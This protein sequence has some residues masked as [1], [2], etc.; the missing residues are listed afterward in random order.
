MRLGGAAA[1]DPR[2]RGAP[3]PT[4]ANGRV[5][6]HGHLWSLPDG[7]GLHAPYGALAR[8]DGTGRLCC[9]LCGRFF[10][11]LGGHVRSHGYT[12]AAYR[13][14]MGLGTTTV[15]VAPDV[16]ARISARQTARWDADVG[17]RE[18]FAAG[19]EMARSGELGRRSAAARAVTERRERSVAQ[20]AALD[21]G[22]ASMAAE[23][24]NDLARR[25]AQLGSPSLTEHLRRRYADGA[26]VAAL[27]A[28]TG[29]G[30]ARLRAETDRAG[31]VRRAPGSTTP[32]GRRARA[33]RADAVAAARIGT[34]D[35]VGWLVERRAAGRPL[36]ELAAAVGHSTHWVRWRLPSVPEHE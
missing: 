36:S 14:T 5:S 6:G 12:A 1:E 34:E 23:R 17:V 9:H 33:V 13:E 31:V 22:R 15:L 25:L 27:A 7:T 26:S 16:G 2:R 19:Q 18:A 29:L 3:D 28:E 32:A 35:L 8:E 20:R 4:R 10:R 24:E 30:R 21:Q 11:S